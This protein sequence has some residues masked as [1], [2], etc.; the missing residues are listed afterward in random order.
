[1]KEKEVLCLQCP[2]SEFLD[3]SKEICYKTGG[4]WCVPLGRVVGKYDTCH[5]EDGERGG[6]G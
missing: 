4:L 1:M 5:M 2:H 3:P 6:G